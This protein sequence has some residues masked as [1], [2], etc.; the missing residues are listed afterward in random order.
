MVVRM[1]DLSNMNRLIRHE[2]N[3]NRYLP[4]DVG[5][6]AGVTLG[7]RG[8]STR[9]CTTGGTSDPWGTYWSKRSISSMSRHDLYE[10]LLLIVLPC[11]LMLVVRVP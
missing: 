8:D 4:V 3:A 6:T 11:P 1:V 5:C 10:G 7:H 9:T 2:F